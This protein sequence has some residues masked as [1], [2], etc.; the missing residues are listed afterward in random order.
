MLSKRLFVLAAAA[1]VLAACGRGE[2]PAGDTLVVAAT[3]VPHAEILEIVKPKLAAEGIN[4]QVRVFN[5]YVQPNLLVDQGQADANYFQTKPYLDEFNKERGTHLV[6]VAGVHV[7]PFG[8]YSR[9]YK[10][11]ADLPKGALVAIPNEPS[12][13]GRALLLLHKAGLIQLK[14]PTN[15]LSTLKDIVANPKQV[16]FRELEAAT[17]PRVLDQVDLALINTNYALDAGLNPSKDALAIE[18]ADSPYVNFLVARADRVNDPKIQKLAA[19]LRSPE[20]K[21]FIEGKYQ[22]AVLPAF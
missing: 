5:D 14:D 12:N 19:A 18:S 10:A 15:A 4:L 2:K 20:V 7:E 13:G 8:A 1:V 3:A 21:T 17:L 16:K 6:P 9:R 22:G 11:I